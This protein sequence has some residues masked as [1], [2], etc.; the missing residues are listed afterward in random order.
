[1]DKD[2]PA[3]IREQRA[4]DRFGTF[5]YQ[6]WVLP[7]HKCLYV[8]VGK[9][10]CT[11]VKA[12]LLQLDGQTL[13]KSPGRIHDM[14]KHLSDFPADRVAEILSSPDW[15]RFCFVRNPYYRLFSAYKSKML[16]YLDPQYRWVRDEIRASCGYPLRNGIPAGVVTFRD[17]VTFVEARLETVPDGHWSRQTDL[18]RPELIPYGEIGRFEHFQHDFERILRRLHAPDELLA[19]CTDVMNPT[20][21]MYHAAVYDRE[22]AGRVYRMYKADFEAFGYE[23]DSWLFDYDWETEQRSQPEVRS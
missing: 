10:A 5:D 21:K 22:L 1:M 7:N 23:R 8:A 2:L 11:R 19:T 9:N 20:T 15:L 16:D 18:L 6:S 12:T 14:G 13:P 17:Y 4:A 3:R